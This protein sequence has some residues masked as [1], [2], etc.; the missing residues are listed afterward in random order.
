MARTFVDSWPPGIVVTA[1]ERAMTIIWSADC[2][3][4]AYSWVRQRFR[5]RQ[6][7]ASR[8]RLHTTTP[9]ALSGL[10]TTMC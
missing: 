3:F 1:T 6:V 5:S 7:N 4:L 8:H 2:Y 9:L 10:T